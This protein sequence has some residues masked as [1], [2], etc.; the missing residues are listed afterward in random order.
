MMRERHS[1]PPRRRPK[2]RPVRY[3]DRLAAMGEQPSHPLYS[4]YPRWRHSMWFIS[5]FPCF[6]AHHHHFGR[7]EP[8]AVGSGC[9]PDD[10]AA[11]LQ[12]LQNTNQCI[13]RRTDAPIPL[14]RAC[15]PPHVSQARGFDLGVQLPKRL[16]VRGRCDA[17]PELHIIAC[18]A[19]PQ[20]T[21]PPRN[22]F[23]GLAHRR[24]QAL[25][26]LHTVSRQWVMGR[27]RALPCAC[28]SPGACARLSWP[29]RGCDGFRV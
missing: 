25:S 2:A 15:A 24:H 12:A 11:R 19:T 20:T 9:G 18:R 10:L 16:S 22:S 17:V 1:I 5:E 29:W 21:S 28:R 14:Y 6:H 3:S 8:G 26:A 7:V 27:A 4:E 13:C 23:T